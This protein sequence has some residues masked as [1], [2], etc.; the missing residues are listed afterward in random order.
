MLSSTGFS[1]VIVMDDEDPEAVLVVEIQV[2]RF[3]PKE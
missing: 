2:M 1:S 3:V